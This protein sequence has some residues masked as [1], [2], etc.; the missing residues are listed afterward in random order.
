MPVT[1]AAWLLS[2]SRRRRRRRRCRWQRSLPHPW[3]E[4]T[5]RYAISANMDLI[6]I[7]ISITRQMCTKID[8]CLPCL[9]LT[10]NIKENQIELVSPPDRRDLL[11]L[12]ER[13]QRKRQQAT[14]SAAA[15]T[16]ANEATVAQTR[17]IAATNQSIW[18]REKREMP[19]S[20]S[21]LQRWVAKF[22]KRNAQRAF[23]TAPKC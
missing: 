2:S 16:N 15:T 19:S 20:L 9:N 21:H 8:C 1:C 7:F 12:L 5:R 6:C 3:R 17:F 10:F 23:A 18:Q 13:I 14:T 11:G 22:I 4:R